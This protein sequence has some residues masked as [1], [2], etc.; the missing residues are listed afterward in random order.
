ML[1]PFQKHFLISFAVIALVVLGS[2]VAGLF[3]PHGPRTVLEGARASQDFPLL[4]REYA[5]LVDA[6][7]YNL[8]NH[9]GLLEAHLAIPKETRSRHST[10]VRDDSKIQGRYSGYIESTDPRLR[11]IGLYGMGYF[12]A[13]EQQPDRGLEYFD[14]IGNRDMPYLNNSIG[15]LTWHS[16][17]QPDRARPYFEKEIAIKGNVEGAVSNLAGLLWEQRKLGEMDVLSQ[18]A[19]LGPYVPLHVLRYLELAERRFGAYLVTLLQSEADGVTWMS[20]LSS[21]LVALM[22][23]GYLYFVDVFEKE[24]ISLL[25]AVFGMGILSGVLTTVFY[26]LAGAFLGAGETGRGLQDLGFYVF[27]VGLF[28]E[29]AKV[30]PV[31]I[32]VFWW[33]K[34]NESVDILVF[35][36]ASALGFACIENAAYFSRVAIGLIVGR[37]LSAVVLH[38]CLTSLAVYGLFRRRYMRGSGGMLWVFG[39]FGAA[40]LAHGLYDFFI[41]WSAGWGILSGFLLIYLMIVFRRMMENALSQSEFFAQ[42]TFKVN[43]SLYLFYGILSILLMQFSILTVQY[44]LDLSLRNFG[45]NIMK[46]YFLCFILIMDFGNLTLVKHKW[47]SILSRER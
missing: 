24:R 6:D 47:R 38:V 7:V 40:V 30:I 13:R 4:E 25:A 17:G 21:L 27:A 10:T 23:L 32:A 41:T 33:K 37:S 8:E 15:Y 46:F 43:L 31:L 14:K 5:R 39:C 12:L 9:R 29:T 44:G 35:A 28:E 26:D 1:T 18:D 20:L 16:L 45:L 3:V 22:F 11:D 2:W 34:W 19:A 42:S 36:A